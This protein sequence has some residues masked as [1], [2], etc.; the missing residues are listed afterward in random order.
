[1]GKLKNLCI[2]VSWR[3]PGLRGLGDRR[4]YFIEN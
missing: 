1:M 2:P 4:S 3:Q